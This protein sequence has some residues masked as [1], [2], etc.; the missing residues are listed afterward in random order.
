M[1]RT[2][3][4]FEN[5][6]NNNGP[7]S[8]VDMENI[9]NNNAMDYIPNRN[10]INIIVEPAPQSI[11]RNLVEL[12]GGNRNSMNATTST[13]V[14]QFVPTPSITEYEHV[15]S[16]SDFDYQLNEFNECHIDQTLPYYSGTPAASESLNN[17]IEL[18]EEQDPNIFNQNHVSFDK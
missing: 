8:V 7:I 5:S 17:Y 14:D 15:A 3:N 6:Q 18:E 12:N 4:D 10:E 13:T 2:F 9:Q 11:N 1:N 16:N